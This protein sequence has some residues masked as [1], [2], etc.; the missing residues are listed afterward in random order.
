MKKLKNY[1]SIKN[2]HLVLG[3]YESIEAI[4]DA[5][6]IKTPSIYDW[7]RKGYIPE[8]RAYQLESITK[9]KLKARKFLPS[10]LRKVHP[11]Y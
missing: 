10:V 11:K 6:G 8:K 4:A 7:Y 9:G 3:Y 2:F 1:Q 5:L